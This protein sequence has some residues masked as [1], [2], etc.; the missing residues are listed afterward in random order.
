MYLRKLKAKITEQKEGPE[1]PADAAS[2]QAAALQHPPPQSLQPASAKPRVE[3]ESVVNTEVQTKHL[4]IDV[5]TEEEFASGHLPYSVNVPFAQ[6]VS[7][8][9]EFVTSCP[10]TKVVQGNQGKMMMLMGNK[11]PEPV[12]LAQLLVSLGYRRVCVMDGSASVLRNLGYL[13]ATNVTT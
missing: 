5:R 3:K 4:V 11:G 8:E 2:P 1:A 9:Y 13:S 10:V 12:Q 6:A 7:K